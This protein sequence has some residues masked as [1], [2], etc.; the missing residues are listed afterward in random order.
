V[1]IKAGSIADLASKKKQP[2]QIEKRLMEEFKK[3]GKQGA[4]IEEL[5][6]QLLD[7]VASNHSSLARVEESMHE[8]KTTTDRSFR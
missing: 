3:M 7:E 8:L 4:R 2:P 1:V 6:K 5:L